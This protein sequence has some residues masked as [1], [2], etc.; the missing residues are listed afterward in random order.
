MNN[1]TAVD[2]SVTSHTDSISE[3]SCAV[4]HFV[5]EVCVCVCV[6]VWKQGCACMRVNT[7]TILS[8]RLC[9]LCVSVWR[10]GCTCSLMLAVLF[11][12]HPTQMQFYVRASLFTACVCQCVW[13][14]AACT[15]NFNFMSELTH[16][17]VQRT[18][19]AAYVCVCVCV[20]SAQGGRDVGNS[21]CHQVLATCN[22]IWAARMC[23]RPPR[24][25]P[26]PRG[27]E[28]NLRPADTSTTP[29]FQVTY[30]HKHQ[31]GGLSCWR[32][33][34]RPRAQGD[35]TVSHREEQVAAPVEIHS[36]PQSSDMPV[37]MHD[38]TN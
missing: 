21:L 35:D 9:C 25:T 30:T 4:I 38:F 16:A 26:A 8:M 37:L 31:E 10:L 6:C 5:Y 11:F 29:G 27:S 32:G 23:S 14:R 36:A 34:A 19:M 18:W 2:I 15:H 7:A 24:N 28:R 20:L 3:M 17:W 12:F 1:D 33:E 22:P 13:E